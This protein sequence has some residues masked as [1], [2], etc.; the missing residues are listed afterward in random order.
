MSL[1]HRGYNIITYGLGSKKSLIHDFHEEFLSGST[2]DTLYNVCIS[3]Q[4]ASFRNMAILYSYVIWPSS[5]NL[6]STLKGKNYKNKIL[7]YFDIKSDSSRNWILFFFLT[8]QKEKIYIIFVDKDCVV[9]NGYFPSLTLKSVL[10]TISEDILEIE[11]TF[12]TNTE[13]IE[14]IQG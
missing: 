7:K 13:Q 4:H 8:I 9:V 10:N 11:A 14:A 3:K 1:L 6:V 5:T 2:I 12:A